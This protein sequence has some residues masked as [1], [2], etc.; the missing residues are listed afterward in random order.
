MLCFC[1]LR[2]DAVQVGKEA[3]VF[4]HGQIGRQGELLGDVP[5]VFADGIDIPHRVDIPAHCSGPRP[6]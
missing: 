1:W 5:A 3:Q 4:H 6:A 2:R